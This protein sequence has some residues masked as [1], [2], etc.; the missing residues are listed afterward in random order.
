MDKR[1]R[2]VTYPELFWLFIAGSLLGVLIEGI[3]CIF[4]YGRWETH[5]VTVW[6]PF[7]ILYGIG[8]V[9]L[10]VGAVRLEKYNY[11]VQFAVFAFVTTVLEYV[12]GALLKYV[13][14]MRA[15][16][17]S[18]EFLNIDGL[19]CLNF[20]V[21][22]GLVG[23]VF[24]RW[25]VPALKLLFSKMCG[26]GWDIACTCLS[27]FMAVNLVVTVMCIFRWADRHREI[28]PRNQMERYI[29]RTWNDDRMEKRFC[30]WRFIE[31]G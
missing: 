29:D 6:G 5:T 24:S 18:G 4:H 20:T 13:L 28:P 26:T 22:W 31:E 10:Y 27:I 11:A 2:A 3:F 8:A 21:A 1:K 30:E 9:I 7:C 12:C 16:D 17:Y 25:C 14:Q 23:V 15:W 19:V